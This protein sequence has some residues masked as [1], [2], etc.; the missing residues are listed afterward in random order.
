[1]GRLVDAR[2]AQAVTTSLVER[3]ITAQDVKGKPFSRRLRREM[4]HA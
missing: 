2:I 3:A 1:V 4:E